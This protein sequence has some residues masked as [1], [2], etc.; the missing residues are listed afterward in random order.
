[1]ANKHCDS[2]DIEIFLDLIKDLEIK[3]K[4]A[5][6]MLDISEAQ[7]YNWQRKGRM[8][9]HHFWAFQKEITIF[10]EKQK[11]KKMVRIGIID[12]KFLKTLLNE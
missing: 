11:I 8:P 12:T 4:E 10:L 7:F 3:K 5:L 9:N 6:A 1:M 2:I